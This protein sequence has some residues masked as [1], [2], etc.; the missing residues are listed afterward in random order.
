MN[1]GQ[2]ILTTKLLTG[3]GVVQFVKHLPSAQI[4]IS[5]LMTPG[6]WNGVLNQALCSAG[7]LLLPL[8]AAHPAC[9]HAQAHAHALTMNKLLT[10]TF[11]T[12]L[13]FFNKKTEFTIKL[14]KDIKSKRTLNIYSM[15][16][17]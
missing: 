17:T 15:E 13:I 5:G 3:A 10:A 4:V 11:Q 6:S 9:G 16:S 2:L 7:G 12:F 8:P 14:L 1:L